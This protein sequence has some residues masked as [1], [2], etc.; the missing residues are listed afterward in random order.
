MANSRQQLTGPP[1]PGRVVVVVVATGWRAVVVVEVL[2][3][4]EALA[5]EVDE[6]LDVDDVLEVELDEGLEE[7][8]TL[9]RGALV[10]PLGRRLT[11]TNCLESIMA[12]IGQRTDEVDRWRSSEQK[13]RWVAA[14]L[15]DI[16]P[17][18]RGIKGSRH[19]PLLRAAL[20]REAM[21]LMAD[22]Q[23]VA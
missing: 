3:V 17:R 20:Q 19:L 18:R 21:T 15:L 12:Q 9:H 10:E 23:G 7:T 2:L 4:L 6:A 5:L 11:T 22:Q 8:L 16:E 14:A 1:S 13:P